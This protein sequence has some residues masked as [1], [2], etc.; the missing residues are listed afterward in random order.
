MAEDT[1][2][3]SE[4]SSKSSPTRQ[5]ETTHNSHLEPA[6]AFSNICKQLD[7]GIDEGFVEKAWKQYDTIGKQYVLEV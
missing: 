7:P 3:K 4:S 6:T 1:D 2:T 5:S